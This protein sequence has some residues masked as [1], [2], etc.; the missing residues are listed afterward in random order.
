M[1]HWRERAGEKFF[2]FVGNLRYS[3]GLHIL[4]DALAGTQFRAVI[5]GAGPVERVLKQQAARLK[6]DNVDFVGPVGDDD[7]IAL[8]TLCHALTFPSHLRSE[9][10]GI[11]LLEGAMFG[12]AL[13]S[14]EIGTGT[15]YVNVDGETGIVVPPS[16]PQ[17]LRGAMAKLWGDDALTKR[18]GAGA[19]ERFE[20]HFTAAR[21]AES[22]VELY[23]RLTARA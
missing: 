5:V 23:R 19:R 11:S 16:D 12:K 13:I 7:K 14:A 6:L 10:F 22:Y 18:L 17:A 8:L 4:L 9:A 15:S 2:L 20:M 21:M 3:K 1:R